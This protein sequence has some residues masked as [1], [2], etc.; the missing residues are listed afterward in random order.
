MVW[1]FEKYKIIINST[2][3]ILTNGVKYLKYIQV[4][5]A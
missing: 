5:K 3:N 4:F 1:Y 2:Q